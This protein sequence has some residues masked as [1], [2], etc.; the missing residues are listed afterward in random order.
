MIKL[1]AELN[2]YRGVQT[3]CSWDYWNDFFV[4]LLAIHL[5]YTTIDASV[6]WGNALLISCVYALFIQKMNLK[7]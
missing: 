2:Q 4:Q 1:L 7:C 5:V 6:L 3:Y